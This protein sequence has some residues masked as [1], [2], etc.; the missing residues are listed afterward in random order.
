[1][2]GL[3]GVWDAVSHH[4]TF[5]FLAHTRP[6]SAIRY[7]PDGRQLATTSWDRQVVLRKVGR[8]REGKALGGHRDIVAGCCYTP[9]GRQLLSWSADGTM[10]L[11]D[12]E[13]GKDLCTFAGH[14]DRV[15]AGA[16]SPDGGWAASGGRD[17]V[18]KLWSLPQRSE[19]AA[20]KQAAEVRGCFFLLDGESL[21][22]VDAEGWLVLLS[23]P[24][25][26]V[27]A[28]LGTGLKVMCAELSPS[29]TQV[30]LGCADG[31]VHFAAVEGLENALLLVTLA[32]STR[33]KA[34]VLG[35]LIG[36]T[37]ATTAYTYTCPACRRGA[38]L[39]SLPRAP[40]AC[41]GCR[42]RLRP[43]SVLQGQ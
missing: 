10:R 32:Q 22:T 21:L 34:S 14:S 5:Q 7:A 9:D 39:G 8:E 13:L 36:K 18:V 26:E 12:V 35:R 25:L 37:K 3:L 40:F 29:G 38:E 19:A 1:M 31:H 43:S 17:G 15:T 4:P 33:Q 24:A 41:P 28:E 27:Q 20:V 2:E 16:V 30:A 42:R 11:W 23:V 6:I